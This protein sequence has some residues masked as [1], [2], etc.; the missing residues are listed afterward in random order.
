MS[1]PPEPHLLRA[2][3]PSPILV[4]GDE[5]FRVV[6][7]QLITEGAATGITRSC[8]ITIV[9]TKEYPFVFS[10]GVA[11]LNKDRLDAGGH[12]YEV[13]LANTLTSPISAGHLA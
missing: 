12:G 2:S 13:I 5:A 9:S 11:C 7:P 1:G 3:E 8:H 10:T 6:F 4:V